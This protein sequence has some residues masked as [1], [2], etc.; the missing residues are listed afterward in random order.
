MV[1]ARD[2]MPDGGQLIIETGNGDEALEAAAGQGFGRA[3]SAS[4]VRLHSCRHC[5]SYGILDA[6]FQPWQKP[7]NPTDLARKVRA[8][9]DGP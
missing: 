4:Y 1:N 2:A 9:L 8:V 5:A 3:G 6:G 7:F